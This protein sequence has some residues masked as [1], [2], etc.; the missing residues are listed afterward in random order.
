MNYRDEIKAEVEFTLGALLSIFK[1]EQSTSV[2]AGRYAPKNCIA[3][4]VWTSEGLVVV[5][6][7]RDAEIQVTAKRNR[8]V[9]HKGYSRNAFGK[10][11][12]LRDALLDA[13]AAL[14]L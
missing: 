3:L 8:K 14:C 2:L 10:N 4:K 6:E 12:T 11:G 1:I 9:L 13:A 5:K 7:I